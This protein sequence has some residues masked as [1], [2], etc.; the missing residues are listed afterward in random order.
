MSFFHYEDYVI[1]HLDD[2]GALSFSEDALRG[3]RDRYDPLP[4]GED[5]TASLWH[6]TAAWMGLK[7]RAMQ[8]AAQTAAGGAA[9]GDKEGY[10]FSPGVRDVAAHAPVR[11]GEAVRFTGVVRSKRVSKSMTGWGVIEGETRII[12]QDGRLAASFRGFHFAPLRAMRTP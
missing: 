5:L 4:A 7:V 6:L 12:H 9:A 2:F 11:A 1:G 8:A 3:F 10:A